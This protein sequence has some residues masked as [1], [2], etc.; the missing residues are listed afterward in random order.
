MARVLTEV[1][2][3][4]VGHKQIQAVNTSH[5]GSDCPSQADSDREE[6]QL[7]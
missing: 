2:P 6:S 5:A 4:E 3:L 7:G 1:M